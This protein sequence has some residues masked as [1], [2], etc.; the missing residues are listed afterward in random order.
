MRKTTVVLNDTE[1]EL[2][3]WLAKEDLSQ[4]GECCGRALDGLIELGLVEILGPETEHANPFIAKGRGIMFR[5]VRLTRA[6]RAAT[7]GPTK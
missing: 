2:L 4:Y 6:A 1:R 3:D 7:L 5:A